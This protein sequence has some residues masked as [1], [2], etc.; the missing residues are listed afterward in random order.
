MSLVLT[1]LEH[2]DLDVNKCNV[3]SQ[4]SFK[5]A[6]DIKLRCSFIYA[7]GLHKLLVS[8]RYVVNYY[9]MIPVS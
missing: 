5:Y 2:L 4:V 8:V 7:L 1:A 3:L 6:F 9:L